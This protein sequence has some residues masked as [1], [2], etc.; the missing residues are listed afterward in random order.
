LRRT[1]S[2]DQCF[3]IDP[4]PFPLFLH[5]QDPFWW[6]TFSLCFLCNAGLTNPLFVFSKVPASSG[7]Y[8]V[9][10]FPGTPLSSFHALFSFITIPHP[11]PTPHL[12]FCLQSF[13]SFAS[14]LPGPIHCRTFFF[15]KQVFASRSP[16]ESPVFRPLRKGY[17]SSSP[18]QAPPPFIQ[19][20]LPVFRPPLAPEELCKVTKD[21]I[22][23]FPYTC[24][25]PP[26]LSSSTSSFLLFCKSLGVPLIFEIGL[27][28]DFVP[29]S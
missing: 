16:Y 14:G 13:V 10:I 24:V 12:V 17:F 22:F 25:P 15:F 23:L 26:V 8:V 5:L 18:S 9:L 20:L 28:H 3:L 21:F 27:I 11:Y 6:L 7:F 1:S 2:H 29:R 19:E 4:V